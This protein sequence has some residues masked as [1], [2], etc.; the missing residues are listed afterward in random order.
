MAGAWREVLVHGINMLYESL[1]SLRDSTSFTL[2]HVCSIS[3]WHY[4]LLLYSMKPLPLRLSLRMI[5]L[6]ALKTILTFSVSV[7]HVTWW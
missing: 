1:Y 5:S 2:M 7:A 4:F 3:N 6:H